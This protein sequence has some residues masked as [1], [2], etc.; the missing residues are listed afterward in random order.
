M[1]SNPPKQSGNLIKQCCSY[2][3]CVAAAVLLPPT[4]ARSTLRAS[5]LAV[6]ASARAPRG[7][8]LSLRGNAGR[9]NAGRVCW[10]C[11]VWGE[12]L[13]QVHCRVWDPTC[14]P[15]GDDCRNALWRCHCCN[16]ATT[17]RCVF[18][19]RKPLWTHSLS[20]MLTM[21]YQSFHVPIACRETAWS[22]LLCTLSLHI[23]IL[24]DL[25]IYFDF[26]NIRYV[27]NVASEAW[28]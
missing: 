27:L 3:A 12:C 6:D 23:W 11:A 2:F 9:R 18:E 28:L 4:V 7:E 20:E 14:E 10:C 15:R 8:H 21:C 24:S 13:W 22:D 25:S 19:R 16:T 26:W 17:V 1:S 5:W